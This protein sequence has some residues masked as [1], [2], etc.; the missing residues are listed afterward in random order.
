M[1]NDCIYSFSA[2]I[3]ML[4]NLETCKI[5]LSISSL[6]NLGMVWAISYFDIYLPFDFL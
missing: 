5:K 3:S 4:T 1:Q 2:F 6:N